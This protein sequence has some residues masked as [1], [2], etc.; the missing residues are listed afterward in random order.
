MAR[1]GAV[2]IVAVPLLFLAFRASSIHFLARPHLF[3]WL[4]LA[5]SLALI[6]ADRRRASKQI[7]W[8]VP[9][10]LL[11]T[12]MHGGFL[13][14]PVTL[15]LVA[16]GLFIERRLAPAARYLQLAAATAA[17]TLINPYGWAV[18]RHIWETLNSK[19]LAQM[20]QEFQPPWTLND[21]RVY[22]FYALAALGALAAWGLARRGEW[23]GPV[24]IAFFLYASLRSVRHVPLFL[25]ASLPFIAAYYSSLWLRLAAG[26]SR[27]STLGIFNDLSHDLTPQLARLSPLGLVLF[28][29]A[30]ALPGHLGMP[31]DFD[32]SKFPA[33]LI[34]QHTAELKQG[35][36]L[37]HDG[38]ADYLE[39]HHAPAIK[40]WV[41][42]RNDFFGPTFGEQYFSL[43]DAE[44]ATA[45]LLAQWQFTTVL[46]KPNTRLATWLTHQADWHEQARDKQAVL[47]VR[48]G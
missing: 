23:V 14:L 29:A 20:V 13:T 18:H 28:A 22:V 1:S 26:A 4:F 48:R 34:A 32:S 39:F 15:G 40:V 27:K 38:W 17:V 41:D 24:V 19:W 12:N 10:S 33:Q 16:T 2:A 6:T 3:T 9:L 7:W 25:L 44:P 31:T 46:I 43:I 42:G 21:E 36:L 37:T 30:L 11:W 47:F 45:A 8:L 35:R 5:A